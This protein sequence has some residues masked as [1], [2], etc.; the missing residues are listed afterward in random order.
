MIKKI[1]HIADVHIPKSITRHDEY[2]EVFKTLFRSLRKDKPDRIVIVGDLVHD[3]LDLQGEQIVLVKELLYG[4]TK[5]APVR[6]TRG[7]HDIRKKNLQRTDSIQAIVDVIDNKKIIYYN[8]TG[9]HDDD[10]VSWA[11][12]KHG[13]KDNSPWELL[14]DK[15]YKQNLTVIDLF[16]NPI[17]GCISPLGYEFNS[18]NITKPSD[19]HGHFSMFGDIHL[20]QYFSDKTKGYSSSL[21]EQSFAEGDGKFH[22]YLLW[23]ISGS[24]SVKEVSIENDF[25]YNSIAINQF[26][27]FED[28][29]LEVENEKPTMKVRV[30][31]RTY[32][33]TRT[34]E[35]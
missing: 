18:T 4:L 26:T 27:D 24:G 22:G 10:N 6:I 5:I 19:F 1:A 31:W 16:H 3:F 35:N 12:W 25:A 14:G 32:T 33:A 17:G 30:V 28:L 20:Q 11:V 7:N 15:T 13:V 9:F 29:D 2:R 8:E 34:R 21:I 23:D